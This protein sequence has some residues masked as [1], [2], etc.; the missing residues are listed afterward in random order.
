MAGWRKGLLLTAFF[1]SGGAGLIYEITWLKALSLIFGGTV[2]AVTTVLVAFMGGLGLGSWWL[3]RRFDR[4]P[5]P[6]RAYTLLELSIA[7]T[8]PLT[9]ALLPW[10]REVYF[11]VGGGVAVRF[12][13]SVLL[14][15]APTILMGGTFPVMLRVFRAG[16]AETGRPVGRLY[17]LNTAGAV[18]GTFAAGFLLIS[19]LGILSTALFAAVCNTLAAA[20]A[21]F[22]AGSWTAPDAAADTAGPEPSG[23]KTGESVAWVAFI[24]GATAMILEVAWTRLL[25]TPLGSSTYGFTVMLAA[26]LV[27]I[28]GGSQLFVFW[29]RRGA[30]GRTGLAVVLLATMVAGLVSLLVW[31]RVPEILFWLMN[32]YGDSFRHMVAVQFAGAFLILLLPALLYGLS[33]PWIAALYAPQE[34]GAARRVGRLYAVNTAGSICGTIGAGFLLIPRFGSYAALAVAIFASGLAGVFL[35][36]GRRRLVA[37]AGLAVLACATVIP[38]FFSRTLVDQEAVVPWHFHDARYQS[39]LN[40]REVAAMRDTL[41]L[42]DGLHATVAVVR[43]EDQVVLRVNGKVDASTGDM[44]TQVLVAALPLAMHRAPRR[45]LIIGFGSGATTNV[46]ARWPG[47]ERVDTVE[48]EPAVL[49]AAPYLRDLNQEVYRHPRSHLVVDDARHF[50]FTSRERYDVIISEPSNPWMAGVANLFTTEF[51]KEVRSRL[52]EGGV[53]A[54][55]VQGYAFL[56]EDMAL[57]GRSMTGVFPQ[58]ALWHALN[59]DYLLVASPSSDFARPDTAQFRALFEPDAVPK[60]ASAG[61]P[62]EL[63]NLLSRHMGLEQPEGIWAYFLLGSK[64]L[65]RFCGPGERNTDDLPLLEYR[66]PLRLALRFDRSL[67]TAL[68]KARSRELPLQLSA[69]SRLALAET[70]YRLGEFPASRRVGQPLTAVMP[71][72]TR[73][74]IYAGRVDRKLRKL[75]DAEYCFRK[76]IEKGDRVQGLAGMAMVAVDR[77]KPEAEALLREAI[78]AAGSSRQDYVTEMKMALALRLTNSWRL[79]EAIAVQKE[80]LAGAP[81]SPYLRW[82][83]LAEMLRRNNDVVEAERTARLSLSMDAAAPQAHMVLAELFLAT[84]RTADAAREFLTLLR[85]QPGAQFQLYERAAEA[86]A[87]SGDRREA[88]RVLARGREIFGLPVPVTR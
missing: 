25:A 5:R 30:A 46:A 58:T 41:F 8:A 19:T 49:R 12:A 40:L 29:K 34:Q 11:G 70:L 69:E 39:R 14:L 87:R 80:V 4:H 47:V 66:A 59:S 68:Q 26:F 43:M 63:R 67:P 38:G 54:Q 42:E 60:T 18:A 85:L 28:A 20:L 52:G 86:L 71:D 27:G 33:F 57:V 78:Q 45:V 81:P 21:F 13:G 76:A 72:S 36:P 50:L 65:A 1:L 16:Q 53:F 23:L 2:Y 37:L 24:T 64:E 44:R 17:A 56:P 32:H 31:R 79:S 62:A 75:D 83:E 6:A 15:L 10:L 88:A 22:T 82:S 7:V 35:L 74:W 3:G 61:D 73:L 48:I 77:G 51:Y 84:G 55:W 9:F